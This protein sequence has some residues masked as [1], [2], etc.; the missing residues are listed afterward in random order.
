MEAFNG[1]VTIIHE[2][3]GPHCVYYWYCLLYNP[4]SAGQLTLLSCQLCQPGCV[5]KIDNSKYVG[6]KQTRRYR[7]WIHCQDHF[8]ARCPFYCLQFYWSVRKVLNWYHSFKITLSDL[9]G[10]PV[11][12]HHPPPG[13]KFSQFHAVFLKKVAK[14]YAGAPWRV[15][16]TPMGNLP[17]LLFNSK[18]Y[19]ASV[20]NPITPHTL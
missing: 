6:P 4:P 7:L 10:A 9:G 15:A 11:G 16:P 5:D 8:L 20:A 17:L 19:M 18:K 1:K 12:A 13:P 14:L 2:G 3:L